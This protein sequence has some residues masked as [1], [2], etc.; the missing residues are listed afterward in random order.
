MQKVITVNTHTNTM[1]KEPFSETEFP[2]LNEY[3]EDGYKVIEAIPITTQAENSYM[4]AI[5]F[6]LE[7]AD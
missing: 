2:Q 1:G 3:L 7:K 5:C 6:I 4:Y